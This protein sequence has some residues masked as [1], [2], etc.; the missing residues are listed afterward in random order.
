[1]AE[2]LFK[3]GITHGDLNGTGYEIIIKALSDNKMMELCLPVVYGLSKAASFHRK[4]LE[5][6]D[7]S[8]QFIK[9]T[10][11]VSL[12]KPSLINIYE[13][14]VKIVLGTSTKVAGQ[15]AERALYMAGRDLKNR[16]IDAIVTAPIN[17]ENIQSE[18]FNFPGHTEFFEHYFG[19]TERKALLMK[20]NGDLRV[21]FVNHRMAND[22][23]ISKEQIS[24]KIEILNRSLHQDFGIANPTIAVLSPNGEERQKEII[25]AIELSFQNRINAFGPFDADKLFRGDGRTRFDAVMA[26]YPEQPNLPDTLS[27]PN[28]TLFTAGLPI[29]HTEPNHGPDYEEAGKNHSDG[30]SMRNALYLALDILHHRQHP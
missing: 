6:Q 15:M 7:F 26:L 25:S 19:G 16:Q 14:E 8:F 21:G 20:I 28:T 17:A 27:D 29:V 3:I 18:K 12:K 5:I 22:N 13:E 9:N 1:M 2:K 4:A 24:E 30:Q 10:D 23:Q 11:Q